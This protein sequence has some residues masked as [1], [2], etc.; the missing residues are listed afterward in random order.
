MDTSGA[1][2]FDDDAHEKLFHEMFSLRLQVRSYSLARDIIYKHKLSSKKKRSKALGKEIK[3]ST[4]KPK[5]NEWKEQYR[6]S[7]N[8]KSIYL[9]L[10]KLF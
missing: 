4:E 9:K 7:T 6:Y 2:N 10:R 3:N 5:I 8:Y 1:D